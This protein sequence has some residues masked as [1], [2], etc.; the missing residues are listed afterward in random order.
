MKKNEGYFDYILCSDSCNCSAAVPVS[1]HCSKA[2]CELACDEGTLARLSESERVPYGETLLALI[3]VRR[4]GNPVLAATTMTAGKRQ[5][6]E[7]IRRIAEHKRPV[8]I[9]LIAV[10]ALT[11][12]A[13][14]ATFAG[15]VRK[16]PETLDFSTGNVIQGM[17]KGF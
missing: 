3:P 6:K 14:A 4:G 12:I 13:C 2:D 1:Q 9:A 7:R 11:G 17:V 16:E 15:A 10:L 5:M 8:A